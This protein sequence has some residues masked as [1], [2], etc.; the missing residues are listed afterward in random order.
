MKNEAT[1]I[2]VST[3]GTPRRYVRHDT[4]RVAFFFFF[5]FPVKRF[6]PHYDTHSR[7]PRLS[8][9]APCALFRRI[10]RV[11]C[12]AWQGRNKRD[13]LLM[14]HRR[15]I[16]FI[17]FPLLRR[18][19]GIPRYGAVYKPRSRLL[20]KNAQLAFFLSRRS[21]ILPVAR[22]RPAAHRIKTAEMKT[23]NTI[24]GEG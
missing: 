15:N 8:P 9:E 22:N 5:F 20:C 21:W 12:P 4:Y 19:R 7:A 16:N 18:T 11:I 2:D 17:Y 23:S 24:T 3:S 6:Y 10:D 1:T 13:T 14:A